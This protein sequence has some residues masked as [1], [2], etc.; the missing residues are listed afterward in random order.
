MSSIGD[1]NCVYLCVYHIYCIYLCGIKLLFYQF[2]F[3]ERK[4]N[5]TKLHSNQGIN[6]EQGLSDI[7]QINEIK[8]IRKQ[9]ISL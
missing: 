3:F 9:G 2:L 4:L 5:I 1:V 8:V 6:G 7:Q